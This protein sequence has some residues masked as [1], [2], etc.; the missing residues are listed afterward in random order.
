M[1]P[2]TGGII[3]ATTKD[4]TSLQQI[5]SQDPFALAGVAEYE[6]LEFSP[7]KHIDALKPIIEK[8]EGPLC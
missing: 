2:R 6:Y 1:N 3:I 4:K 7:I 5:M 8:T